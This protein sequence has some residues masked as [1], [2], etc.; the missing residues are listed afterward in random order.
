MLEARLRQLLMAVRDHARNHGIRAEFNLHREQSSLVRLGNSAVALSTSAQLTRL[1]VG[2]TDGRR[3]GS[4][5]L[6]AD[7]VAEAQVLDALARARDY[8]AA[9]PEKDYE[10]IFGCVE[11]DVADDSGCDPALAEYAP[12]CKAELCA[13]VITTLKPRGHYDFSGSWSTGITEMYYLTTANDREAWRQLTDGR[14]FLVLKEQ[15]RKWELAGELAGPNAQL[16]AA[17]AMTAQLAPLLPLYEGQPGWKPCLGGHRVIFGPQAI[18]D[19]VQLSV[20]GGFWGRGWEEKR[21]FTAGKPFGTRLFSELVTIV[22]DPAATGVY[23]MSFDFSGRRRR[24]FPLCENGLFRGLLYDTVTA[25]K[26]H[27]Q[28]TGHDLNNADLVFATGNGPAGLTAAKALA[29]DAL[30]VPYLHYI[31]LPNPSTGEFTG[32]SRFNALRVAGGEFAAPL[33]STRFTDTIPNV[34][35][36]VVAVG[37]R[38][39]LVDISNTYGRRAPTAVSVPEYLICDN[40]RVSD[41]ADAF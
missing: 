15:D 30:Y 24:R 26:Y 7:V 25:A 5:S 10:P 19:L 2:V 36:H 38:P 6:T 23:R 40:V 37:P 13:Q 27:R 8:C 35:S 28:P 11:E 32:S 21:A 33:L 39:V 12:E 4:Y 3:T 17:E 20:W 1:D 18:A 9:S 31:H 41:V 29:G 14:W 34:L 16:F 22:D